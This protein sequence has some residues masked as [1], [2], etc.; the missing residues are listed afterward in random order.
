VRQLSPA[1]GQSLISSGDHERA[2][3]ELEVAEKLDATLPR[4]EYSLGLAYHQ[5]GRS[6]EALAAFSKELV[7][8]PDD[9][10]T[11]Y[12]VALLSEA[13]GNVD[14]AQRHL[15]TAMKQVPDSPDANALLGKILFKR[16]KIAEAV[17]PLEFAVSKN[18]VDSERRYL[19]ARIYQQLGRRED[20]AREFAEVQKLRAK[21][22]EQDR[23]RTPKP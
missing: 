9:F 21:Q 6:K 3:A 15:E 22:L 7:R 23:A 8:R 4:L 16:G 14:E 18:P 5:L 10:L 12:Y 20:A 13:Q 1:Q 2:I 11:L 17:T 19:L